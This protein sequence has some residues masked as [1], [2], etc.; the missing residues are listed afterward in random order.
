MLVDLDNGTEL[1]LQGEHSAPLMGGAFSPDGSLVATSGDDGS[2][3][4]WDAATG[5]LVET[6]TGHDGRVWAPTFSD[7]R[8]ST[9]PCTPSSL[10]G[11]MMTWDLSGSRRLGEPFQAG[12]GTDGLPGQADAAPHIAVSPDGRL[13]ATNDVDGVVIRRRHDACGRS[14]RSRPLGRT[15]RSTRRGHRTA[16]GWRSRAPGRR[17]WSCTTRRPGSSSLRAAVH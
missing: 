14:P 6:L 15:A 3:R 10:D 17:S 7:A 13:L 9:S 5:Y 16:P 12:A 1:T 4:L 11:T 2:T 8:R